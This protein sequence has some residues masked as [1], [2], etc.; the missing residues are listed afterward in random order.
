MTTPADSFPLPKLAVLNFKDART[1]VRDLKL[2]WALKFEGVGTDQTVRDTTPT[3]GT[4]VQKGISV[5]IFVKGTAP[6]AVVPSIVG[7]PCSQAA[8]LIVDAGLYPDYKTAAR[9]GTV[10]PAATPTGLHW[11]DKMALT[12]SG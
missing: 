9:T 1:T 2:G 5:T 8:D 3:A 11:N 10:Q 12:C 6:L 7:K 4:L